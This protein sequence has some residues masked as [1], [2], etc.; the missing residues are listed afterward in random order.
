MPHA[1]W[2]SV[3]EEDKLKEATRDFEYLSDFENI[4][5]D[6]YVDNMCMRAVANLSIVEL[7]AVCV[8]HYLKLSQ[9]LISCFLAFS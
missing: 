1:H 8:Q 7:T 9:Q 3:S 6:G 2:V 4:V 5:D